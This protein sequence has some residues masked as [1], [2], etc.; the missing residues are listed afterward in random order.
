MATFFVPRSDGCLHTGT[1]IFRRGVALLV[2]LAVTG[3]ETAPAVAKTLKNPDPAAVKAEVKKMGVGEHVMVRLAAG[4][5]TPW[6][7][8]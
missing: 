3:A 7:Y 5:K 6:A 8:C 4:K 2:A 1:V